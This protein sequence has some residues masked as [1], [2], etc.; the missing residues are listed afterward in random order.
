MMGH[1]KIKIIKTRGGWGGVS[2][3][4]CKPNMFCHSLQKNWA[5][6]MYNVVIIV[7]H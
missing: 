4:K 6:K 7:T 2:R 1:L 5:L 3:T